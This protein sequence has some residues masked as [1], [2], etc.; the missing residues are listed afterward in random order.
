MTSAADISMT[1]SLPKLVNIICF[2]LSSEH[3]VCIMRNLSTAILERIFDHLLFEKGALAICTSVNKTFLEQSAK[4]LYM[5]LVVK[6]NY[7]IRWVED[8][9][10]VVSG[11][12]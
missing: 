4:R 12:I 8:G 7:D 11:F 9:N 3:A 6:S 10:K 2:L 1:R 5:Q